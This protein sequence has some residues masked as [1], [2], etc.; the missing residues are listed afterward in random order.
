VYRAVDQHGQVI[1]DVVF[2]RRDI[3]SARRFFTTALAAHRS[4][5]EVVTDRAQALANVIE[6]LIPAGFHNTGQYE[7]NRCECDHGWLKA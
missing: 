6:E 5:A 1:D 3:A 2:K 7:N 4:P